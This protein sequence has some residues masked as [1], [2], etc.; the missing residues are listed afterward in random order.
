MGDAVHGV[1][2][3]DREDTGMTKREAFSIALE[4]EGLA[5]LS[6]ESIVP[7]IEVGGILDGLVKSSPKVREALRGFASA[8]VLEELGLTET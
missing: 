6:I 4:V 2:G 7:G 8:K 1:G 3:R 5:L